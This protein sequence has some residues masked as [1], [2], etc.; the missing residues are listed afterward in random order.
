MVSVKVDWI[1]PCVEW[2]NENLT[3][4]CNELM[5]LLKAEILEQRNSVEGCL[6][7][8]MLS[9]YYEATQ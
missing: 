1:F 3:L 7:R 9:Y 4:F 2:I 6:I 5:A 8:N